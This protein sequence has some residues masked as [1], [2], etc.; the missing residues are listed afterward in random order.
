MWLP[1]RYVSHIQTEGVKTI[2]MGNQMKYSPGTVGF[3]VQGMNEYFKS[4]GAGV[5]GSHDVL[6]TEDVDADTDDDL[7]EA[8]GEEYVYA[9]EIYGDDTQFEQLSEEGEEVSDLR[10]EAGTGY[11]KGAIIYGK[12]DKIQPSSGKYVGIFKV[13]IP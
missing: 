7:F 1:L 10:K 9:I 2:T 13:S 11:P 3:H 5:A 8:D 6:G 12:F 4:L